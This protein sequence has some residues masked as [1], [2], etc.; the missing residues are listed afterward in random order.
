M[1][2]VVVVW[3][4]WCGADGDGGVSMRLFWRC[5]VVVV[6]EKLMWSQ[7]VVMVKWCVMLGSQRHLEVN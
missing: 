6:V 3:C 1:C 7:L 2:G 5:C 4:W